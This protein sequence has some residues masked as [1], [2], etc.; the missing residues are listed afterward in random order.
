MCG[1]EAQKQP[2]GVVAATAQ[3]MPP[4]DLLRGVSREG[5]TNGVR[6][7][8]VAGMNEQTRKSRGGGHY[9]LAWLC[10]P[11]G[12][13]ARSLVS[14]GGWRK[15]C[16]GVAE[17][18]SGELRLGDRLTRSASLACVCLWFVG[19]LISVLQALAFLRFSSASAPAF[20]T[21]FGGACSVHAGCCSTASERGGENISFL[22][23]AKSFVGIN[24][25]PNI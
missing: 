5:L 13:I 3:P 23:G 24:F 21:A 16:F 22:L 14:S 18:F 17:G 9:C 12:R 6:Y 25:T 11:D 20:G 10:D 2:N 19:G 7:A 15:E 4:H 1:M 8:I